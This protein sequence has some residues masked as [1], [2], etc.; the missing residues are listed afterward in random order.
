MIKNLGLYFNNIVKKN[1]NKIAISFSVDNKY[2]FGE[3]NEISESFLIYFQSIGLKTNDKIVIE[4]KKNIYT[5]AIIISFLKL[6]IPYAFIDTTQ[7]PS[8]FTKII[9]KIKPKKIF[10]FDKKIKIKNS[11]FLSKEKINTIRK[12][13]INRNYK[14]NNTSTIAYIM[15]T[16]GSTGEPK[17]VKITHSNLFYLI[18]WSKKFFNI[19]NRTVF[20]NLNPLHFD[21]SVF[22]IYC[23]LF[24]CASIVPVK[25]N[26]IFYF[27]K[28]VKKLNS[29]KCNI[30]FSVPSLLNIILTFN[31]P[32]VFKEIKIKN[33]IFGGEPFPINSARKIKKF[34][35]KI[36]FFNVSGPT[37]CTCICSAHKVNESELF[38][39]KNLYVGKINNYFNYKIKPIAKE[40]NIGE[41]YLEGPAVSEGYVNDQLKTKEKFYK[42]NKFYGYKTGD[43][44]EQYKNKFIKIIGRVDNQIKILGHRIEL[45]EIENVVN[46]V[47]LLNQ[48]LVV[49]K[50]KKTFPF[51]KLQ[52]ITN[53][54]KISEDKLVKNL[55]KYLPKY[56][57]P[58][59]VKF[60]KSFKL[61]SNGKI[62]RKFYE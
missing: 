55:P 52:L 9:K 3:L 19:S 50:K 21:N 18:K 14:I 16:S 47:F 56:M 4:S 60:I 49:L 5:Y 13:K 42:V 28:L 15:F 32:E 31:K 53:S 26:E 43:I 59:E 34:S 44:V 33:F 25:K 22:D 10:I 29:L 2:T 6:G 37:E 41:L 62:D 24:N 23:S 40:K 45:E 27:S 48:S 51:K 58:E 36:N 46:Q 39:E 54:R 17:G 8:R 35:K 7:A 57:M 12:K 11:I 1:S 61:N 20:T 30:W 38:N